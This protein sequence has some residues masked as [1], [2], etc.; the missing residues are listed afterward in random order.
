VLVDQSLADGIMDAAVLAR[1]ET[2]VRPEALRWND[3]LTGQL[4]KVNSGLD[5]LEARAADLEGRVDLGT[6]AFGCALGYLDFRFPSL[7]W[8]DR[9]PKAAA[10][11]QAFGARESMVATRPPPA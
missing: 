1:Y 11:F 4:Q 9:R 5:T 8:R 3:W 2:A 10:W 6:I 7:A